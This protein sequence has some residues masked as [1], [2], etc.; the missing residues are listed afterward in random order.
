LVCP[1]FCVLDVKP[2]G[3]FGHFHARVLLPLFDDSESKLQ[4]DKCKEGKRNYFQRL[5]AVLLEAVLLEAVLLE[6]VLL[7]AVLLEAVLLE[8]VLLEA[9]LLNNEWSG[10][11]WLLALV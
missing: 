3:V 1:D 7:E 6:A 4:I 10:P 5:E 11:L 8:A 9:V 2:C